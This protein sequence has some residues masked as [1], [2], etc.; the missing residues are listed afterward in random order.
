MI[1]FSL[2]CEKNPD[3]CLDHAHYRDK[4]MPLPKGRMGDSVLSCTIDKGLAGGAPGAPALDIAMCHFPRN[5]AAS[6]PLCLALTCPDAD[7]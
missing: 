5:W 7:F 3:A 1:K 4:H 2:M 6:H